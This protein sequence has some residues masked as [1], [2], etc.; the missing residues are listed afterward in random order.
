MGISVIGGSTGG[1]INL[2]GPG[3]FSLSIPSGAF[4]IT[5]SH[6]L[7]LNSN[8]YSAGTRVAYINSTITSATLGGEV[9]QSLSAW[10]PSGLSV[11]YDGYY[12][13]GLYVVVGTGG[14]YATSPDGVTWTART[15]PSAGAFTGISYGNGLWVAQDSTNRRV[16]TSTNAIS[17]TLRYTLT[18]GDFVSAWDGGG[19]R[20]EGTNWIIPIQGPSVAGGVLWS[21]DGISWTYTGLSSSYRSWSAYA[22][23]GKWIIGN[24]SGRIHYSTDDGSNWTQVSTGISGNIYGINKHQSLYVFAAGGGLVWTSPTGISSFTQRTISAGAETLTSVESALDAVWIESNAGNLY[25][26]TDGITWASS[27]LSG[28]PSD[29]V[30]RKLPNTGELIFLY[31]PA[32]SRK[33]GFIPNSSLAVIEQLGAV[34]LPNA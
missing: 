25:K 16:Y 20:N 6:G 22:E 24:D 29:S 30:M 26:S 13:N 3:S 34:T 15:M 28:V 21:R 23:D 8:S 7:T 1:S 12:G 2:A 5:A 27:G 32:T 14:N 9:A 31:N 18:T 4:R 11:H 17:W 33:L 19:P 10:G